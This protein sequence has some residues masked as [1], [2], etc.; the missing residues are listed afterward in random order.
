MIAAM[1]MSAALIAGLCILAYTLAIYALPFMLAV[2]AARFAYT[3]GSG[4]IGAGL[5]G[6]VAGA[7]CLWP[8]G[9]RR[10]RRRRGL[11]PCPRRHARG[12]A[13]RGLAADL[14][15][16][17]QRFRRRIG[18]V[19]VGRA[20]SGNQRI[21]RPWSLRD[22]A[23]HRVATTA[24]PAPT[25]TPPAVQLTRRTIFGLRRSLRARLARIT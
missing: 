21:S 11:R 24:T 25:M 17:R 19:A 4:L 22:R 10:A 9:V 14:L 2:E 13:V 8:A 23:R 15:H 3:I 18:I 20:C 6:L 7:A 16:H 1:L 12:R 5:V